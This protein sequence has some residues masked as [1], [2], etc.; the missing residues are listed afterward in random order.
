MFPRV[1]AGLA[2]LEMEHGC[3]LGRRGL[4]SSLRPASGGV[5]LPLR[6]LHGTQEQTMFSDEVSLLR[7]RGMTWSRF[8]SLR[9][10]LWPQYWQVLW[11]RSK[12][13]WRVN[14]TSFFGMRS[15]KRRRMTLGTRILNER[16]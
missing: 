1:V 8:R 11:S 5:R 14:F 3:D 6:L 15:K 4:C 10:H 9:S 13:L 7:S 16:C 2:E 12:M